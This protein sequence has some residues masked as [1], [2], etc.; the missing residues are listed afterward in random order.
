MKAT[1]PLNKLRIQCQVAAVSLAF[2]S[3]SRKFIV[4]DVMPYYVDRSG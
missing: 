1:A 2:G 3:N 4:P